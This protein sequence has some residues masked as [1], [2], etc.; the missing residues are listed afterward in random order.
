MNNP[1]QKITKFMI[2]ELEK[3]DGRFIRWSTLTKKEEKEIDAN[4][5]LENNLNF[6]DNI[7]PGEFESVDFPFLFS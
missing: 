2:G 6:C 7:S 3:T 1:L 4:R 5:E